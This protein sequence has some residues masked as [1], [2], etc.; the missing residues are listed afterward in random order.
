MK[1]GKPLKSSTVALCGV[2]SALAMVIMLAGS[3]AGLGVYAA[4]M[5]AGIVLST[6][7]L[8]AGRRAQLAAYVCVGA[9]SAILLGDWEEILMFVCVFGWYP[10]ARPTFEKLPKQ[11]RL[12]VKALALNIPAV[13]TEWLVM[14]VLA[15]E[16]ETAVMLLAL[17]VM[18]NAVFVLY[19]RMIPRL[20]NVIVHRLRIGGENQWKEKQK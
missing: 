19:D 4:P 14:K 6:V 8:K 12:P 11:L 17:W 2:A 3:I 7:G 15:P 16:S 1:N 18:G 20:E 5:L 13:G 9:L 10:A